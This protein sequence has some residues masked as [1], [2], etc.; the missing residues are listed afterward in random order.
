MVTTVAQQL[1]KA[2]IELE[3]AIDEEGVKG[4]LGWDDVNPSAITKD[5]KQLPCQRPRTP[6]MVTV[7]TV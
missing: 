3:G 6:M 2:G 7:R 1:I 5:L 4:W